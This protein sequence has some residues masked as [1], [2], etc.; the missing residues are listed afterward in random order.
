[1]KM[2]L[3]Q[4]AKDREKKASEWL[5][6]KYKGEVGVIEGKMKE[7]EGDKQEEEKQ[8]EN[9][10]SKWNQQEKKKATRAGIVSVCL[11]LVSAIA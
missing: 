4:G 11:V 9:R 1:M 3:V 10:V 2:A 5:G 8:K 6:K 7:E